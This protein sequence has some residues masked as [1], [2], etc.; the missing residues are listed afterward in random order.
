MQPRPLWGKRV[1]GRGDNNSPASVSCT[2]EINEEQYNSN[3]K[4]N[5]RPFLKS[6]GCINMAFSHN[7]PGSFATGERQMVIRKRPYIW[8]GC[9]S[10]WATVRNLSF[11][12]P[13]C[14]R[15]HLPSSHPLGQVSYCYDCSLNTRP[16]HTYAHTHTLSRP[17]LC[18]SAKRGINTPPLTACTHVI[19]GRKRRGGGGG[20]QGWT[21]RRRKRRTT[22]GEEGNVDECRARGQRVRERGGKKRADKKNVQR[23]ETNK[24]KQQHI[25][26]HRAGVSVG[27][28]DGG[29]G[30]GAAKVEERWEIK[31]K[32]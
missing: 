11:H 6:A 14:P 16:T 3:T 25:I 29:Q 30:W 8:R 18:L 9:L 7:V 32:R 28:G 26:T 22:T 20:E 31:G 4:G 15:T 27:V 21:C 23:S 1:S 5:S 2:S 24:R 12:L 17:L 19:E 13:A 10:G